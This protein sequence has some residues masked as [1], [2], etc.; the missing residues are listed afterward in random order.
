MKITKAKLKQII[1]EELS[2]LS[3]GFGGDG[4]HYEDETAGLD[5]FS[6]AAGMVEKIGTMIRVKYPDDM[7]VLNFIDDIRDRLK[8]MASG[9]G[10]ETAMSQ[11]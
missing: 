1:Q 4:G 6:V 11:W 2:S 9:A 3:E 7:E 8:G 5:P 10:N